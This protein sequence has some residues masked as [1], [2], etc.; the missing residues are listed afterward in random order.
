[1]TIK[2]CT[3][4][5]V[6]IT[7]STQLLESSGTLAIMTFFIFLIGV[8]FQTAFASGDHPEYFKYQILETDETTST[9]TENSFKSIPYL[10]YSLHY[11]DLQ[12][13]K[14]TVEITHDWK[15][16][17]FSAW[18]YPG[19][20][21]EH[22]TVNFWGGLARIPGMNNEAHALTACHEFGHL[23]GGEP[24]IKLKDFLW[25][26][27]EG[28][29]DYFAS[30]ICLKRYFALLHKAKPLTIPDN[31][32]EVSFTQC[33]VTFA[34]DKDFLICLNISKAIEGFKHVLQHLTQYQKEVAIDSPN[35][36]VVK[37]T[38]FNS[39]PEEQCRIDTLF[40]GSLCPEKDFP[41]TKNQ[42]GSRPSCWY[43][44]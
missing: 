33:R 22:Y 43:K 10:V 40:Q 23:L 19:E 38:I 7:H 1:V 3:S 18:V 26:S 17:F 27:S 32:P 13:A 6:K 9:V 29:S 39:Y 31:I 37:T 24:F 42:V 5:V 2:R 15:K 30:G 25:S 21:A 35:R 34:E 44:H 12:K 11:Q 41:C 20:K 8:L 36:S 14:R 4:G 28:Q 16:P